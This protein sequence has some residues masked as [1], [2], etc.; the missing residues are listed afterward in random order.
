MTYKDLIDWAM[1][2]VNMGSDVLYDLCPKC[3]NET[4]FDEEIGMFC[5]TYCEWVGDREELVEDIINYGD[6]EKMP[7]NGGD[8][9]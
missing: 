5:C 8:N 6:E 1:K 3:K 4:F 2:G 7:N 9:E